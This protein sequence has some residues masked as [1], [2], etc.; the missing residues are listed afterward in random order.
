[1]YDIIVIG[2]GTAGLTAAL[3]A[4]RAGKSV[5]VAETENIGGQITYAPEVE[6]YPGIMNISGSE[7]VDNLYNQVISHGAEVVIENVL[8]I[9]NGEKEKRVIT[10]DGEYLCKSIIIATGVKRRLLGVEREEDFTGAGVSYCAICDGAF[11]KNRDV[12]VVGGGNTAVEDAIYLSAFCKNVYLIHRRDAFRAEARHVDVLYE[13]ENIKLVLD[14]T[15]EE[16]LGEGELE[17]VKL[18]NTK[19]GDVSTIF[20]EGVFVAI[21]QVP[22]NGIF[23]NIVKL[24]ESGFIAA[25]E[26]CKTSAAG[27]FTAGDCRTKEIR[28]LSTAAADGAVAAL[29][30]CSYIDSL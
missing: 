4:R 5:L 25:G 9:K 15:V 12:A 19:T 20:V 29:A 7:F 24:D 6:N 30:A 27:I 26:D 3:Y 22:S 18:K 8:E 13:K 23:E 21:G 16:L 1:M 2:G 14:A 17:G 28:Q 11:F 10:E